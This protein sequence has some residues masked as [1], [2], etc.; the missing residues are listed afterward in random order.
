MKPRFVRPSLID[1]FRYSG[2]ADR[3]PSREP[4]ITYLRAHVLSGACGVQATLT[5]IEPRWPLNWV[6][7]VVNRLPPRY[8]DPIAMWLRDIRS[9]KP[10][11][12]Y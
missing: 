8:R 6:Y 12:K 4:K 2:L 11:L 10:P 5:V 1:V 9:P 7:M 3:P